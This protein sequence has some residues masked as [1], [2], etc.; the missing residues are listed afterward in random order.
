VR[1]TTLRLAVLGLALPLVGCSAD[2][3]VDDVDTWVAPAWFA[4]QAQ[5]REEY[6][7]ALQACL[8]G[9][10]WD[11][12]VNRDGGVDEALTD[13]DMARLPADVDG[14]RLSM[15]LPA[16][17]PAPT[18]EELRDHY[19]KLLDVRECLV[20]QGIAMAPAQSQDAWLDAE[21]RASAATTDEERAAVDLWHPYD[22]DEIAALPGDRQEEL[23]G[24]CPQPWSA[25]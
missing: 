12:T 4:E 21:A 18:E 10:G 25:G 5:E 17:P 6:Q 14:C 20:A 22:D 3:P 15:G 11:L 13:A 7:V 16:E 23:F 1:A 9:K 2:A 24:L 19:A 8:D